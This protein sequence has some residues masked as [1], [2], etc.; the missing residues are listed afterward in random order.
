VTTLY[1]PGPPTEDDP[2]RM[3]A[4]D[5]DPEREMPPVY[6]PQHVPWMLG[7]RDLMDWMRDHGQDPH[8]VASITPWDEG[9]TVASFRTYIRNEEGHRYLDR[10]LPGVVVPAFVDVPVVLWGERPPYRTP[11]GHR[12]GCCG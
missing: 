8:A 9:W 7:D 2:V 4:L 3:V 1:Y 11:T 5:Y 6:D 10:S 12:L